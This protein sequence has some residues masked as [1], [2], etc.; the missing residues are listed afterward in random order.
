[1]S[2][3]CGFLVDEPRDD[4]YGERAEDSRHYPPGRHRFFHDTQHCEVCNVDEER[5]RG[6]SAQRL[7]D[8]L[9]NL[10]A[11]FPNDEPS[12]NENPERL[13]DGWQSCGCKNKK[14]TGVQP[15]QSA[16]LPQKEAKAKGKIPSHHVW[17][18]IP[19]MPGV[20]NERNQ[21]LESGT[22]PKSPETRHVGPSRHG[23]AIGWD[24]ED[25]KEKQMD[26]DEGFDEPERDRVTGVWPDEIAEEEERGRV[27]S[28]AQLK[29]QQNGKGWNG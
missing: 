11:S 29:E 13:G 24:A 21:M 10:E 15:A 7:N 16:R 5:R 28:L 22:D 17:N 6:E 12:S 27:N 19:Q 18:S 8:P 3:R 14:N 2:Y 26:L 9:W 25:E 4:P 20:P 23:G 1:M